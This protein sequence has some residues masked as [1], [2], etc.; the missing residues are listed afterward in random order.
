MRNLLKALLI[1]IVGSIFLYFYNMLVPKNV[2]YFIVIIPF[3]I[4]GYIGFRKLF[5]EAL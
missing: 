3:I 5:R 2:L 4:L 1:I